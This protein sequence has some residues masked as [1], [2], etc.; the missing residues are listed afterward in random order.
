MEPGGDGAMNKFFG[1]GGMQSTEGSVDFRLQG[2]RQR[3]DAGVC[4]GLV[5]GDQGV[6]IR[7][8]YFSRGDYKRET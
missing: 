7:G 6:P 5:V 2:E 3:V 4:V 8:T 1:G